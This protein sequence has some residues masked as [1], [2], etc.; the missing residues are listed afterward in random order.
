MRPVMQRHSHAGNDRRM[1]ALA[2]VTAGDFARSY[3]RLLRTNQAG[4]LLSAHC[5]DPDR[6]RLA[7]LVDHLP[8]AADSD[9]VLRQRN[10]VQPAEQESYCKQRSRRCTIH[11]NAN[12]DVQG[13]QPAPR[14][15]ISA[16]CG[17]RTCLPRDV[18]ACAKGIERLPIH[19]D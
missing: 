19:K 3:P 12:A 1:Q 16:T 2:T 13:A 6:P 5:Q 11:E 8:V 9:A 10:L 14:C 7:V 15:T 4:P 18:R 17:S